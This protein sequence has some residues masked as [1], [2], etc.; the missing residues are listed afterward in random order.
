MRSL[1]IVGAVLIVL[2][3]AGLAFDQFSYT[4]N[5]P[6]LDAGPIH[7]QAEKEHHVAIPTIASIVALIAGLGLI[8]VSRRSA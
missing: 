5:K 6:V 2:G 3:I 1:A 4:E 7:V 8:V